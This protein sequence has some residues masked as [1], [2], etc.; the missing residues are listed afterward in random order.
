MPMARSTIRM[1]ILEGFDY[2]VASV[3]I[4]D[5][6]WTG[7]AMTARIVRAVRNPFG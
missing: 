3:H 2:V 5:S 6:G 1:T 7:R 4:P